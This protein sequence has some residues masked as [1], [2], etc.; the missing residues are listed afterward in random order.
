MNKRFFNVLKG[1][2]FSRI[3]KK[4]PL[5][6]MHFITFRC[7]L[8]CK[9]CGIWNYRMKEM[10][11]K[12][13][14]KAIKEFADAGTFH[15]IFTGGEPLLRNDIGE[16]IKYLKDFG[17]VVTLT[18]NGV[19]LKKRLNEIKNVSYLVVSLDG[20][21]EIN[22]LVRGE[23]V[24]KQ[25]IEGVKVVREKNIEVVLNS[26]ISKANIEKKFYGIKKILSIAEELNCKLNFSV[27]YKDKFNQKNLFNKKRIESVFPVHKKIIKALDFI[28]KCKSKKP[29]LIM[30][31]DPNIEQLK[32]LKSWKE[33][34]A[35]KLFCD[36]FPDGRVIPCLFKPEQGING[37]KHGF[38]KAFESLSINKNC[39]CP[40]TCYNELNCTFS[41]KP[42]TIWENF[43]KYIFLAK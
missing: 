42:K 10:G 19:L 34:Y 28:K 29:G 7:N 21:E 3:G 24:F 41:L 30:F 6:V 27:I 37:L 11:T 13:I 40:S 15:W 33:C 43:M 32:I 25:V 22:D 20:P 18:T 17:I 2:L 12:Q 23:G 31:S 16:I 14:K 26:V 5:R 8:R 39:V 1:V 4:V 36:L 35:G 38:V 9:Y